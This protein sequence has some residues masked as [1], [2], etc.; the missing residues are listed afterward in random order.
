[1]KKTH[2]YAFGTLALSL[3]TVLTCSDPLLSQPA[4]PHRKPPPGRRD[5]NAVRPD[6]P[7]DGPDDRNGPDDGNGP[8]GPRGARPPR[9]EV[10][11]VEDM[12][13][14]LH[15][16][17]EQQ[18]KI[19]KILDSTQRQI[20]AALTTAQRAKLRQ[21]RA[22]HGPRPV[23]RL[24]PTDQMA[25]PTARLVARRLALTMAPALGVLSVKTRL[26]TT[27]HRRR[28]RITDAR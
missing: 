2:A 3:G 22:Q 24:I 9:L 16:T 12:T 13:Q 8:G 6:G 4:A 28:T 17:P 14:V 15:L 10:S 23:A 11:A 7:P 20:D 19:K 5:D 27:L 18:T 26:M 25:L 21:M 1:M